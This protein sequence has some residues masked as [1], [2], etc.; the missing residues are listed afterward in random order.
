[1]NQ[2]LPA[3]SSALFILSYLSWKQVHLCGNKG[4]LLGEQA[5]LNVHPDY[6]VWVIWMKHF[7]AFLVALPLSA[8]GC[9]HRGEFC[10]TDNKNQLSTQH[11][12]KASHYPI[13][14][15]KATSSLGKLL[16]CV[17]F[18]QFL[19]FKAICTDKIYILSF[20]MELFLF[21]F[22]FF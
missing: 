14:S 4:L 6:V 2:L 16:S 18:M 21:S 3:I 17:P 9:C 1:M 19:Q 8:E 10:L 15:V 7:Q 12:V 20:I 22:L 13:L 5:I 11:S